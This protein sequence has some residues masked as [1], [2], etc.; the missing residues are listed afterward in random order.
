MDFKFGYLESH[1]LLHDGSLKPSLLGGNKTVLMIKSDNCSVCKTDL[2]RFKAISSRIKNSLMYAANP[3]VGM[4]L[5]KKYLQMDLTFVPVYIG[6]ERNSGNHL[7]YSRLMS[8]DAV[9]KF[10]Q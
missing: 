7:S 10:V 1:D 4:V 8:I 6:I 5:V 9:E 2:P 3:D